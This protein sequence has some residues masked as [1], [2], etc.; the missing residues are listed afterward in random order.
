MTA[1]LK[2]AKRRYDLPVA[3]AIGLF[4]LLWGMRTSPRTADELASGFSAL[5]YAIPVMH[6]VVMPIG[7]AVLASRLWDAE[8][9]GDHCKLLFTLQSRESL[10]AAKAVMGLLMNAFICAIEAV[11]MIVIGETKGVTEP[12]A[13]AQY[14]WLIACTFTVNAMLFFFALLL[15][16]RS[17]TQIPTLAVGMVGSLLG[18]FTAFMPEIVSWFIPW[19]YYVPLMGVAMEW[20]RETRICTFFVRPFNVVLLAVAAALAA[21]CVMACW[22]AIRDKEV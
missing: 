13:G 4:V 2:K 20:D 1:E 21:A 22:H 5:F 11:G 17:S 12:L 16:I 10:F 9:K 8:T 3:A 14:A 15:S 18:L 19:G 6:T 7:M